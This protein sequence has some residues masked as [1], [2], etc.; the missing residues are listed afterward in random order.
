MNRRRYG[1]ILNLFISGVTFLTLTA[2]TNQHKKSNFTL[3]AAASLS[4]VI[5]PAFLTLQ[6]SFPDFRFVFNFASSSM[7][8]RQIIAGARP[9]IFISANREWMSKLTT[10]KVIQP[11]RVQSF[12]KNKL[13]A[14]QPRQ[15]AVKLG[16][17]ADLQ[18][19]AIQRIALGDPAHVPVGKY[20]KSALQNVGLWE[21]IEPKIIPAM[22]ARAAL[23]FVESRE[24]DAGIAYLTDAGSSDK[25]NMAF[26][27]PD[28]AQ[29]DIQ[30]QI[31]L[32][33]NNPRNRQLLR[34]FLT[35]KAINEI[36]AEAGFIVSVKEK[37]MV[38]F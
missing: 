7:L 26:I 3:F 15:S 25:V 28:S 31:A 8:A 24:V 13:V 32:I 21:K 29:P 19:K 5:P 23:V 27:F 36:F 16:E 37:R 2:C 14:I 18:K 34:I 20:A 17:L 11:N 35:S 22:D 1:Q 30:Y 4:H 6:D 9:E 38:V 12:M 33:K 10:D